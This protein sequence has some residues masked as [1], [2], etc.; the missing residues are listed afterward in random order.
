MKKHPMSYVSELRGVPFFL[1]L[2][3]EV[4]PL[5]FRVVKIEISKFDQGG[6]L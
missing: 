5:D 3:L 4:V 6:G 2:D 1:C